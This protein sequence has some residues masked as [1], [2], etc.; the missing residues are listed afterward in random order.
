MKLRK[1]MNQKY[2][3]KRQRTHKWNK[4]HFNILERIIIL[5]TYM[6]NLL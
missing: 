1:T 6:F 5:K 4:H 3:K 2:K